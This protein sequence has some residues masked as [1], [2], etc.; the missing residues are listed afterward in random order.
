[1]AHSKKICK[2]LHLPVQSGS[3]DILKK[4]NRRYTK[5]QYLLLV[6]KNQKGNSI[7]SITTDIVG[8]PGETEEDFR[9][10]WM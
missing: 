7:F 3:T 5:E 10:R 9:K 8:F 4:M 1:M 6:E 2:H